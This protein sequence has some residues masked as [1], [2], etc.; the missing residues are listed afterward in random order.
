MAV[1][2]QEPADETDNVEPDT[3]HPAVPA[4]VTAKVTAPVPVPPEVAK[5]SVLP[6]STD[7]VVTVNDA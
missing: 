4:V 7:V 6:K 3:E 1:T 5:L 2:V